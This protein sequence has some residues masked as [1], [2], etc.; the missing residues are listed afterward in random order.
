M[1]EKPWKSIETCVY[2]CDGGFDIR[3]L[4]NAVERAALIVRSV[5]A[6]PELVAALEELHT[7]VWGECPSLLNEDSGGN[8]VLDVRIRDLFSK[9]KG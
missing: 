9:V 7:L 2:T 6:L 1:S 5:N 3:N 4:P 8:G